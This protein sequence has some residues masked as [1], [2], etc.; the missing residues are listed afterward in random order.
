MV[1]LKHLLF[2][3]RISPVTIDLEQFKYVVMENPITYDESPKGD[4]HEEE[5]DST[6]QESGDSWD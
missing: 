1:P 2:F 3:R 4:A 6:L 5:H